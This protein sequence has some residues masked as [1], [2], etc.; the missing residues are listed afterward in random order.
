MKKKDSIKKTAT[1]N[2]T[3]D[4]KE[5]MNASENTVIVN[6]QWSEKGDYIKKFSMYE[7]YSPVEISGSTT[8]NS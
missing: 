1:N 5:I 8:L 2:F 6:T 7:D 4:Y 3:E